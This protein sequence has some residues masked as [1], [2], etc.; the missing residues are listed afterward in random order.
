MARKELDFFFLQLGVIS[1]FQEALPNWANAD[2]EANHT[3]MCVATRERQMPGTATFAG[4]PADGETTNGSSSWQQPLG[5]LA[6]ATSDQVS[7][8]YLGLHPLKVNES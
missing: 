3:R 2:I 5:S 7:A 1:L 8:P 4:R 6:P